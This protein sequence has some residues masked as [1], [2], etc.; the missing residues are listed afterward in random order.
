MPMNKSLGYNS[1]DKVQRSKDPMSKENSNMMMEN[2]L[3]ESQL[4][5]EVDK[6]TKMLDLINRV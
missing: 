6:E 5:D 4:K 3:I 2:S 1:I